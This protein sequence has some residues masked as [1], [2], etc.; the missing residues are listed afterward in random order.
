M[1]RVIIPKKFLNEL[2]Q[3]FGSCDKNPNTLSGGQGG[4]LYYTNSLEKERESADAF[5]ELQSQLFREMVRRAGARERVKVSEGQEPGEL[6]T[7]VTCPALPRGLG[8]GR[9]ER[10]LLPSSF[11]TRLPHSTGPPA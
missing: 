11:P 7:G 9:A 6:W 2:Y 1:L 3:D 10:P 5:T 4:R 8:Q